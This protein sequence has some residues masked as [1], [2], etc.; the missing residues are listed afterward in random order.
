MQSERK[1]I[2]AETITNAV[3]RMG[4]IPG[5]TKLE[6][7]KLRYSHA[8]FTENVRQSAF[9]LSRYAYAEVYTSNVVT[10]QKIIDETNLSSSYDVE[11]FHVLIAINMITPR[12]Y[13]NLIID[14]R[15]P[16]TIK[17]PLILIKNELP[18]KHLISPQNRYFCE[19]DDLRKNESGFYLEMQ[20]PKY[21]IKKKLKKRMLQHPR[22]IFD[23]G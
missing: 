3:M 9:T 6:R 19:L 18:P 4:R 8:S 7:E 21:H 20:I 16:E 12:I 5:F 23:F 1:R 13:E 14:F 11:G 10:V 17:L 15:E 2:R 22:T